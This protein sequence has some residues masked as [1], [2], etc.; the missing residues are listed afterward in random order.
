[1]KRLILFAAV[2]L[3]F[4]T[5]AIAQNG[6]VK[7]TATKLSDAQLDQVTAGGLLLFNP[8][9]RVVPLDMTAP[10]S[11]WSCMNC[12]ELKSMYEQFGPGGVKISVDASGQPVMKYI[13]KWSSLNQ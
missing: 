1:M 10:I 5:G 7:S 12:A 13:G 2:A 4:S 9:K 8:G 6:A 11:E 3:A